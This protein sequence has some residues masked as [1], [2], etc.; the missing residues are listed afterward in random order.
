MAL[1]YDKPLYILAFDH[2]GSF[3]KPFGFSG[4]LGSAERERL[5][6]GKMLIFEGVQRAIADG[7]LKDR[8]G[9]LV[10]EEFG[11]DI[12]R[13]AKKDDL[14]F[15]MPAEKSGQD[16]F[17]FEHGDDFGSHIEE[18]GRASCRERV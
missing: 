1:G 12:L 13:Q 3:K 5:S 6:D 8:T 18:I 16:E 7:A 14:V 11:A 9:I 15:A 4:D 10:D 17:D 2:R